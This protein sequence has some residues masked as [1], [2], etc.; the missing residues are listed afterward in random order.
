MRCG[1][2]EKSGGR[3]CAAAC[4]IAV[5][6]CAYSSFALANNTPPSESVANDQ[7]VAQAMITFPR[8]PTDLDPLSASDRELEQYG[9]PPRPD[10]RSAPEA[11]ARWQKLVRV[12][13]GPNP[14]LTQ[15]T[16]YNGPARYKL[17]GEALSGGTR[18]SY[19]YNWSGYAVVGANGTFTPNK[20]FIYL[21]WV[22]PV[23]EQANKTCNGFWD[24][25]VQW[26]GFD[27]FNSK[28]VLQ[29]GTEAD[30]YCSGSRKD[31]FYSTWI[32]WY[33]FP[34]VRVS[35]PA[36]K[37]GDIMSSQVWYTVSSPHGHA[38]LVNW[39]LHQS[40]TY[41]FNPRSGTTFAGNSAEW[42]LERPGLGAQGISDLANYT[43]DQ[44]NFAHAYNNTNDFYP[45]S[46]P[47]GTTIYNISMICPPWTPGSSC[48]SE[49]VISKPD[50]YGTYRVW[51]HDYRPAY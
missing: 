34:E 17:T 2:F 32:E 1:L 14:A 3:L 37:P 12:P 45:G 39:T 22:V 9:F 30:A 33:P 29:A 13:R 20:T 46:S 24:Y 51:F 18:S 7:S 10:A 48:S 4:V 41:A 23:A 40:Q 8:P 19:S 38:Y 36:V 21:E 27:G 25:S 6:L 49:T 11:Y 28:D 35:V 43:A 5:V 16:L 31:T 42:V 50:L 26:D 47:G 15:T 44:F